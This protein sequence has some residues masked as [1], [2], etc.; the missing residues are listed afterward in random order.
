MVGVACGAGLCGSR[1]YMTLLYGL[2]QSQQY[3]KPHHGGRACHAG[4]SSCRRRRR[5]CFRRLAAAASRLP[6]PRLGS[7]LPLRLA[8]KRPA[9]PGGHHM[10]N[11]PSLHTP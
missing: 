3:L 8:Q 1:L 6:G 11:C 2:D 4:R 5:V 9:A 10:L 7:G